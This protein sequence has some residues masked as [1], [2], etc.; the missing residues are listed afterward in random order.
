MSQTIPT[1]IDAPP[2]LAVMQVML[3]DVH[4][5]LL[6]EA[7]SRDNSFEFSVFSFELKTENSKLFSVP[8]VTRVG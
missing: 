2:R 6:S 4:E 7:T 8:R 3:R 1:P 5:K